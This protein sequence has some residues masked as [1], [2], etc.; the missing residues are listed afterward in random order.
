M[1]TLLRQLGYSIAIALA[2][3]LSLAPVTNSFGQES[4]QKGKMRGE[5]FEAMVK[6]LNLTPEQQLQ[7]ASLKNKEKESGVDLMQKMKD[8]RMRLSQELDKGSID[9][10]KVYSNIAEMKELIGKRIEQRVDRIIALK[11]ILTPEQFKAFS[12]KM[13]HGMRQK[14]GKR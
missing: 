13:D 5:R 3:S 1:K 7:I 8:C 14:G 11:E 12:A 4:E 9:K 2:V 6:E 10:A